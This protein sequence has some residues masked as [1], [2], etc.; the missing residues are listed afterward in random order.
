MLSEEVSFASERIQSKDEVTHTWKLL[1]VD[2]DAEVHTVTKLALRGF[3]YNDQELEFISAY[4]AAEARSL[5][6]EH[7]D[8]AIILLDVV[9]ETDNAGLEL[10]KFIRKEI[11]NNQVRIIL[12][13]G[14]PGMAPE[15]AVIDGYDID[16]YKAKTELTAQKLY[17]TIATALRSYREIHRIEKI[18]LQRTHEIQTKNTE[19]ENLND[20][21]SKLNSDLL[22]S[23][24]Y[25]AR[26]QKSMLPEQQIMQK[27]F[28]ESF[29]IYEPK[30]VLG[31]DFYWFSYNRNSFY[32]AAADCTGHGVPGAMMSVLGLSLLAQ[33]TGTF[34]FAPT[35]AILDELHSRILA[36]ITNEPGQGRSKDGMELAL[37]RILPVDTAE[38]E[39]SNSRFSVLH[40]HDDQV[41]FLESDNQE[42]G[43]DEG[44]ERIPYST[45]RIPLNIGDTFYLF[46][47]GI[48][49]Q[50]S[51]E[52]KRKLGS[53]K[54][55]EW[56]TDL[57]PL[58]LPDQKI[59]LHKQITKWRGDHRQIDDIMVIAF[60]IS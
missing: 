17:T 48:F 22:D 39:Y 3:N 29:I 45:H 10:V 52:S 1:I 12:R 47:D 2:D 34:P 54:F 26:L 25:A 30:D 18:V 15:R 28:P 42:I 37:L 7:T 46:S 4:S 19:L 51:G 36:T 23:I 58:N 13:T 21:L 16:D 40:F 53:K 57:Q 43:T 50:F 35:G 32:I 6:K 56:L 20:K 49:D 60:R 27:L 55:I 44:A 5:L 31:G 38:V 14:Q 11:G 41:T 8:V 9:M 59:A 33:I 24:S